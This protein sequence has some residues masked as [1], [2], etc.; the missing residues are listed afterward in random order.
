MGVGSDAVGED[1]AELFLELARIHLACGEPAKARA[2]LE[3]LASWNYSYQDVAKLLAEVKKPAAPAPAATPSQGVAEAFD[4]ERIRAGIDVLQRHPLLAGF[5]LPQLRALYDTCERQRIRAGHVL[6]QANATNDHL[7]VV[8]QGEAV[9][10]SIE[11]GKTVH[12]ATLGAGSWFGEMALL[13]DAPASAEVRANTA[14]AVLAIRHTDFRHLLATHPDMAAGFFEHFSGE[15]A[16]R[17]RNANTRLQ[18]QS[19]SVEASV[20]DTPPPVQMEG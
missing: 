11:D 14:L 4:D 10:E 5:T 9:V 6:I 13:S 18:L 15:L 8:I 7:F 17:L 3:Q 16:R 19:N 1:N 12:L 2:P 20:E